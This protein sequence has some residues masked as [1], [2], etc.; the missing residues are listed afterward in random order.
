MRPAELGALVGAVLLAVALF[1]PWF[2]LAGV[3]RDG[4]STQ[5]GAAVVSALGAASALALVAVTLTQRSPSL[6]LG[7]AVSTLLLALVATILVAVAAAAPPVASV[8]CFGLWLALGGA[9]CLV[10]SAWLSLRDE[11]P[12]WGVAAP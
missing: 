9:L 7:A 10:A 6:P 8:R 12:F 4:W 5:T 1:E 2:E 11:R 3:R